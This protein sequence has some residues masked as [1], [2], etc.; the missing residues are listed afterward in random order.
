MW[1]AA[2][3][4]GLTHSHSGPASRRRLSAVRAHRHLRLARLGPLV[5]IV[6]PPERGPGRAATAATGASPR[7]TAATP[8]PT[9]SPTSSN[10]PATTPLPT[11]W[12]SAPSSTAGRRLVDHPGMSA[13]CR[14]VARGGPS[15][16]FTAGAPLAP[17]RRAKRDKYR[18]TLRSR[19]E[20]VSG[21]LGLASHHRNVVPVRSPGTPTAHP[22][23]PVMPLNTVPTAPSYDHAPDR[24][25]SNRA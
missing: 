4:T 8:T 24:C 3:A 23:T 25:R 12:P 9:A 20:R 1:T 7:P 14:H 13:G 22:P 21:R 10:T 11:R 18:T 15:L 19:K 6:R 2:N 5:L 16:T 17:D